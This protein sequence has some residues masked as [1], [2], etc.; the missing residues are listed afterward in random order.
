ME[1]KQHF[2]SLLGSKKIQII[3]LLLFLFLT[4]ISYGVLR[5]KDDIITQEEANTLF[6]QNKIEK[7]LIDGDY[8]HIKT[9]DQGYKIYKDAINTTSFFSK[10]PVE[11]KRRQCIFV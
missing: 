9:A 10:Y 4:L 7:L 11:V 1:T 6:T 2:N 3:L 8:I 5:D